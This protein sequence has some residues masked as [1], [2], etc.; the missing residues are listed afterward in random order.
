MLLELAADVNLDR[1]WK[2]V[3]TNYNG[4]SS[5]VF[6]SGKSARRIMTVINQETFAVAC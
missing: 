2:E 3:S 1:G 5:R 4:L 6:R